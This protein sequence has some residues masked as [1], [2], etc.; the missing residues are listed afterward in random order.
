LQ[1]Q[2]SEVGTDQGMLLKRSFIFIAGLMLAS[3][4]ASAVANTS[5]DG[6][7]SSIDASAV[8]SRASIQKLPSHYHALSLNVSAMKSVLSGAPLEQPRQSGDPMYL[9]MPDGSFRKFLVEESPMMAPGLAFRYPEFSTYRIVAANDPATTGRVDFTS[10][11]FHAMITG[12]D[13]TVFIDPANLQTTTEYI[14]FQKAHAAPL[15]EPWQCL[16]EDDGREPLEV[17]ASPL[18][19]LG[20]NLP[21]GTELRTYRTAV[22]A[23]VEYTAFWGGTVEAGMAA[24]VTAINRVNQ[25]YNRDLAIHLE[26]IANNDDVVYASNPDPFTN[27]NGVTMLGQNQTNMDAVIGDANYD[28]GHVFSTG[29][30]G[31]ATL[32][33]PCDTGSKARGVT[34]LGNPSGDAFYIDYVAHEIGHQF[35]GL[36]T[37]NGG[38]GNC[39]GGNR[40]A[41]AAYEPGSGSTIQA[42]AGICGAENLQ[43]NSDANFHTH[44][45]QEIIAYTTVGEGD[46]CP[47]TTATGNFVPVPDSGPAY[48]IPIS[49]PFMLT[50]SATDAD[51]DSL[52]YS[53]EQYDL[54]NAG[55]PNTDDGNRPIFRSFPPA[56][57]PTRL[58]PKL[59]DILSNSSTFG[60]SLPTTSRSLTFRMTVRD[61]ALGGGGSDFATVVLTTT[62]NAG[63]F[64]VTSQNTATDW[65][66][67]SSKVVTWDVANTTDSPVSC[68]QVDI[69]FS[70][71][72]GENFSINLASSVAND[73][74]QSV[75]APD[76]PTLV[77]RV[78]VKCSNNIFFDIN[79]A[80]ITISGAGQQTVCSNPDLAIPDGDSNGV[81]D[82]IVLTGGDALNNLFVSIV[83]DHSR[84]G[85]L[86]FTLSRNETATTALLIDR[87]GV[88]GTEFGCE[89]DD[90][91]VLLDDNAIV[92]VESLC[93][94]S[95]PAISGFASPNELLSDFN[96]ENRP[97]T[98]NL[99][100]SD[101]VSG[102]TGTLTSWCITSNVGDTDSDGVPDL[103]DNC[104]DDSNPQQEDFDADGMGYVCDI[105]CASNMDFMYTFI[106]GDSFNLQA[107]DSILFKGMINSGADVT[108]DAGQG[109]SLKPD[110]TI[111]TGA[112]FTVLTTGC[113]P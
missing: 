44:S 97:G 66:A 65:P 1:K 24:I 93:A 56:V 43:S 102:D 88:P 53:W 40:S 96:G 55:P 60:E 13:G 30:G 99:L 6:I 100:V 107:S 54:G 110:T 79:N 73:G 37:F 26:L 101:N 104:P 83:A 42:Y 81:S 112:L 75:T 12:P 23:T 35:N 80:P 77:G 48:T 4:F 69:D 89:S 7:W 21:S 25:I 5:P 9:P 72:A 50:G 64:S 8:Q 20:P 109:V 14:S 19:E 28:I 91:D 111:N 49:T 22:A 95:P 47:V 10:L 38:T 27:S 68:N 113:N 45:F 18:L 31:V 87:P 76:N 67:N 63:P 90:I 52:T 15:E 105:S 36:H 94:G 103:V 29:G 71:D 32:N 74:S 16:V 51:P 2:G 70:A 85:D 78:R 84:V 33:G 61:N 108:L 46:D 11:G 86:S 17:M 41:S 3:S 106:N 59:S 58:F 98:W 57:S 39:S 82:S 34:G 92:G 62:N